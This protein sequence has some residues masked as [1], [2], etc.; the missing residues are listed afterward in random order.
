MKRNIIYS[1]LIILV[2]SSCKVGPDY[3]QPVVKSPATFRFDS[4]T[5][6]EDTIIN[7]KWWELFNDPELQ[8]LI[9]TALKNNPDVLIAASRIE[10]ARAVV[11]Y[12]NADKWPTLG[13]DASGARLQTV[14]PGQGAV[15]PYNDISGA[16]T[17]AWELDFWGKYRRA[18]EA[19]RA[20][21]VATEYGLRSV[22]VSLISS[23]ASTYFLLLD[24]D[25][26]L[27]I[28]K[29]TV[30]SRQ[31][32]LRIIGERFDKGIVPEIDLNKVKIQRPIAAPSYQFYKRL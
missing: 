20:E 29:K 7:L 28:S 13:Y 26:R 27:E 8:V 1:L 10:E 9:N 25:S 12:N 5:A 19:A 24:Y 3:K 32:S 14:V 11:G 23:V 6:Q 21:L 16:A 15:G 18:T 30:E 17:L 22:Q 4:I 2:I 31:E